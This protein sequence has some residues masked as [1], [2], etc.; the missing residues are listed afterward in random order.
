MG[1]RT[2]YLVLFMLV[3]AALALP[4]AVAAPDGA[5]PDTTDPDAPRLLEGLGEH[6]F[7]A[8]TANPAARRYFDQGLAL[9]YGFNHAAA[10]EAFDE[11]AKLDPDCAA[12]FWGKAYAL[13]PNINAPMGP[14]AAA[15]AY[16]A[17]QEAL[18]RKAMASPIEQALIDA[19]AT[20]YA[21]KPPD[22]RADLDLA[23]ANA[24]R[25]VRARFPEDTDVATLTAEALMDLYPWNYWDS[26]GQPREHNR[27]I[28]APTTTTSTPWSS[29]P[30]RRRSPPPTAS[31]ASPRTPATSCTCPRT[32]TGGS[33]GTRMPPR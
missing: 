19:L 20:R 26:E 6:R 31:R 24:M 29:T 11:A 3:G 33:G 30:R 22:D 7:P 2:A 14:D 23:Y 27:T 12:C 8:T 17:V 32:S 18:A 28:S 4:S 21:A 16:A 5:R 10:I 25:T 9:T 13:G 15:A 1:H